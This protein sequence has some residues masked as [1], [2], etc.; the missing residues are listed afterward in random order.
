M[1]LHRICAYIVFWCYYF[2][3]LVESLICCCC[4]YVRVVVA[5][6]SIGDPGS[7][8]TTVSRPRNKV[9]RARSQSHVSL[10][11]SLFKRGT[12]KARIM[13]IPINRHP[14]LYKGARGFI[15][16][17]FSLSKNLN[18]GKAT[19]K[20]TIRERGSNAPHCLHCFTA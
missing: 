16:N 8:P 1:H 18:L 2:F 19:L 15:A 14:Y 20:I 3:L 5:A 17:M 12:V 13:N 11:W 4:C 10:F 6:L 9:T 7:T